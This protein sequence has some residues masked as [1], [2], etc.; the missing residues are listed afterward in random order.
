MHNWM[1]FVGRTKPRGFALALTLFLLLILSTVCFGALSVAT[2]DSRSTLED[3]KG[4]RAL[5]AARAGLAAAQAGVARARNEVSGNDNFSAQAKLVTDGDERYAVTVTPAS[6]NDSRKFML[7]KVVS[8]GYFEDA[9]REVEAYLE[10]E[11]FSKF[12]YFTDNEGGT[13]SNPIRFIT[14]DQLTGHVHTNGHFTIAGNPE[15]T[16]RM[17][18]ANNDEKGTYGRFDTVNYR[19]RRSDNRYTY[20]PAE[21]Y[22]AASNNYDTDK[23]LPLNDSEEFSFAGGQTGIPLPTDGGEAINVAKAEN[24]YFEGPHRVVFKNDGTADL[25]KG[26]T[27][28]YGNVNYPSTPTNSISTIREP[29]VTLYFN[30]QTETY[31]DIKGRVTLGSTGNVV[32]P[33]N[34]QYVD[35]TNCVLGILCRQSIYVKTNINVKEDIY[36][37]AVMMCLNGS[38]T[39]D[40]YSSG[41][42][43]GTLH[44]FGGIIQKTRGAVGTSGGYYGRTGYTK[45]YVYDKKLR[46]F[47]PLN[48]PTTGRLIVKYFIDKNSLGGV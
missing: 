16:N 25:Y 10:I 15:F 30:G 42:D 4:A 12:A 40:Q 39:V 27:D 35:D 37:D 46:S 48:Y 38:F 17:T 45:D 19:Y 13:S 33:D 14:G 5:Y 20:D 7:W 34:L 32:I 29:G 22:V 43:R 26:T 44:V 31:G 6:D 36:I 8:I 3:Y 41:R 1:L 28:R 18:S 2:L 21:F 9:V 24:T 11:S 23:P 47:P